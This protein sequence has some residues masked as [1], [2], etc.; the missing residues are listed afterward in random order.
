MKL[1]ID[2]PDHVY[3]HAKNMSE[4]SN[5]EYDAM[6]AIAKGKKEGSQWIPCSERLPEKY[7]TY[8]V[9]VETGAVFEYDYSN[10]TIHNGKWSYCRREILAWMPMPEPY[11]K[12]V[13][14]K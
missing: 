13:E 5:D 7:R 2:I 1:V 14:M 4:D 9:T 12:E 10:L 11:K 3:E 8:I 6:R